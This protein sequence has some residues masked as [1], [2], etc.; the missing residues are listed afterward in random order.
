[1]LRAGHYVVHV[2]VAL[3]NPRS[4]QR[5][6]MVWIGTQ[7]EVERH[8]ER[9]GFWTQGVPRITVATCLLMALLTLWIWWRRRDEVLIGLLGVAAACWAVRT[10]T[11]LLEQI[12]IEV[13]PWWRSA[14]HAATG[15]CVVAMTI[16]AMRFAGRPQP[17]LEK[18]LVAYALIGPA[19]VLAGGLPADAQVGRWWSAGLLL[20]AP[21]MVGWIVH[22]AAHRRSAQAAMLLAVIALAFAAGLHDYLLTWGLPWL[23][24]IAPAWADHRLF[25]LHNTASGLL[26]AAGAIL[27]SRF[28]H[29]LTA[30]ER[31]NLDLEQR[32]AARERELAERFEEVLRLRR[33]HEVEEE[34][35]RITQDMHDG[36]GS[37]LFAAHARHQAG[38]LRPHEVGPVLRDCIAEMRLAIDALA[39][40]DEDFAAALGSF[41]YRWEAQ[42]RAAGV[43]SRWRLGLD[44][45]GDLD[46]PYASR[47][48]VLRI[49]QEALTNVLK[50]AQARHV[51]VVVHSDGHGTRLVVRDDGVGRPTTA[52]PGGR[53]LANMRQRAERIGGHLEVAD[54]NPGTEVRLSLPRRT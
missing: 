27:A 6:P 29:S 41:R 32:V 39:P 33:D 47:L 16:F 48:Q 50:H 10:L 22:A 12:P 37:M 54:A 23:Y 19:W 24:R 44:G 11:F 53:G 31:S 38:E 34:R 14:Y 30:L 8:F 49:L 15:G 5:F 25:L 42:L 9:R 43:E 13:Y 2:R 1:M 7:E 28:V 17:R 20:L 40:A 21:L 36:L 45:G 52:A 4:A 51:D 46:V 26:L 35:R 3:W 18:V